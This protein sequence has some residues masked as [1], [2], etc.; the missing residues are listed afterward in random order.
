MKKTIALLVALFLSPAMQAN[1]PQTVYADA[2]P[3]FRAYWNGAGDALRFDALDVARLGAEDA[4]NDANKSSEYRIGVARPVN[5]NTENSGTWT[6]L[7]DGRSRWLLPVTATDAEH[8]NFGFTTFDIPEGAE[9][10]IINKIGDIAEGPYTRRNR[11][12]HGQLW[13]E[14]LLGDSALIAL[15]VDTNKRAE[16]RLNL[17]QV[18]QGYRGFGTGS[19][20]K[21]GNCNTDPQCMA[22]NDPWNQNRRA[23]AATVRAGTGLC[24]GSLLNN[25][26]NNRRMLFA[27]A[28][29]CGVTAAST[30]TIR[31]YWK[32]E[33]ACREPGSAASGAP[34]GPRPNTSSLGVTFLA[35]TESPFSGAVGPKSD[36]TL[37][38]LE[39][40]PAGNTFELFFAGWDRRPPSTACAEPPAG[41]TLR[42]ENRC[43]SIH[44]PAGDEKRI[45]FV[46]TNMVVDNISFGQGVHWR[47]EWDPTPIP[48]PNMSG[49][50][51]PP[52]VTEGGSSGS[53]L[54]SASRRLVGVLSGG[55]SA[56]GSTGASLRDQYGG[57]FHAWDGLGTA[58]TRMKDYL[59]PVGSNPEFIDGLNASGS[60]QLTAPATAE[61]VCAGS[62]NTRTIR[63]ASADGSIEPVQFQTVSPPA[64]IS[65]VSFTP[66]VAVPSAAGTAVSVQANF[67]A[68]AAA[69]PLTLQVRGTSADGTSDASLSYLV[70]SGAPGS[71]TLSAP[72][73]AATGVATSPS[74]SWTAAAGATS[75]SFELSRSAD[76]SIIG[77]QISTTATNTSVQN[78]TPGVTYYWRVFARNACNQNSV[79]QQ[80]S[81]TTLADDTLLRDGFEDL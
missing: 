71:F 50:P 44:H 5:L 56:C 15:D 18:S 77:R 35:Q 79:V 53:P 61:N 9:L 67:A 20:A 23:V 49:N 58:S 27:T 65:S 30:P 63:L 12:S 24:T 68:A 11:L 64:G 81:F 29:H 62:S 55:P 73:N 78:L 21:S 39:A 31:A 76:F 2:K 41:S 43:A 17:T 13:T 70:S 16:V 10:R 74:F 36:F 72:A 66:T 7:G 46:E 54:Y 60:F 40:P 3:S 51:I 28:T 33:T 22:A 47:A 52:S 1:D 34:R 4:R 80:A 57:L 19:Q 6:S 75:Y 14:V 45:T 8:L 69:G 38:E 37:I 48:L 26:A 32:F 25:T 42:T 59:D